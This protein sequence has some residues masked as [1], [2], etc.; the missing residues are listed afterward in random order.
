MLEGQVPDNAVV[1]LT[2]A[3]LPAVALIAIVPETSGVGIEFTPFAPAPSAIKNQDQT[4][5]YSK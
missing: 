2:K 4:I 3:T 5:Y 1:V